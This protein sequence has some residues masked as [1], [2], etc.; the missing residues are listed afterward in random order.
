MAILALHMAVTVTQ[1]AAFH[2]QYQES[3]NWG[4]QWVQMPNIKLTLKL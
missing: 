4:K 2:L 1:V 3:V